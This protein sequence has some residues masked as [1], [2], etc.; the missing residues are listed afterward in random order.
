MYRIGQGYDIHPM[1]EGRPLKIGGV[2][3]EHDRGPVGNSDGDPLTHA[4]ID[5]LLGAMCDGDIGVHFPESD[6]RWQGADSMEMLSLVMWLAGERKFRLVNLDSTVVMERPRLRP[7]IQSIRERLAKILQVDISC[8]SV[9][10][11]RGEGLDSVGEG[12]AI[13]A[14][15][16]VLLERD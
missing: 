14:T 6:A 13:S 5:A 1:A 12:R 15:A 11:K 8:I 4:I 7:Y 2:E 3:I 16:I 9:K 10:A